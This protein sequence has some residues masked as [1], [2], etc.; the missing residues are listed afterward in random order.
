MD[1]YMGNQTWTIQRNWAIK[2]RPSKETGQSNLDHPKKLG[3]QTWTI[4]RNWAMKE[5]TIE[6]DLNNT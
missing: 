1:T 4:Q 6:I 5:D 3:N 2:A